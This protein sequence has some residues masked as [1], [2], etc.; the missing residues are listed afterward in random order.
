MDILKDGCEH[1]APRLSKE[2]LSVSTHVAGC[3]VVGASA[4]AGSSAGVGAGSVG[5]TVGAGG[6][7]AIDGAGVGADVGTGAGEL[8]IFQPARVE[9]PSEVHVIVPA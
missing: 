3:G 8:H 9:D 5:A 4:G 7:G 1:G 2:P 6:V